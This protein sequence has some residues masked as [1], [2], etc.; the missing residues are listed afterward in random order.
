[1][2]REAIAGGSERI[3]VCNQYGTGFDIAHQER[4]ALWKLKG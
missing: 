4:R 1:M 2:G 3:G